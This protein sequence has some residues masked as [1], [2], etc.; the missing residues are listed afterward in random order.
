[1]PGNYKTWSI[2]GQLT[3]RKYTIG[4]Q[5]HVQSV[6]RSLDSHLASHTGDG[7]V[8]YT[9]QVE[10]A[11]STGQLHLQMELQFGEITRKRD[12]RAFC[13]I[14]GLAGAHVE[15]AKDPNAL[16]DY[17]RKEDSRVAGPWEGGVWSHRAGQ[18]RRTDMEAM[19][20]EIKAGTGTWEM[21]ERTPALGRYTRNIKDLRT[22]YAESLHANQE[23]DVVVT[24]IWGPS[25]SGKTHHVYSKHGKEHVFRVTPPNGNSDGVWF[26]G[27]D[28]RVHT[29]LLL[30]EFTGWIRYEAFKE[31]LDKWPCRLP[32]KGS[33]MWA[34]WDYVY[35]CSVRHP[36]MLY[37]NLTDRSELL[38]RIHTYI[39]YTTVYSHNGGPSIPTIMT[40]AQMLSPDD[41]DLVRSDAMI[42]QAMDMQPANYEASMCHICSYRISE[43][44]CHIDLTQGLSR[45][46]SINLCDA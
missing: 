34:A 26:D 40:A 25:G 38:R 20:E 30:D 8:H 44:M 21:V 7:L 17:C 1:M 16:R 22:A 24:Y 18:G 19:V 23:R 45:A 2:T 46:H 10:K 28:P 33:F 42:L 37:A 41:T 12:V 13:A 32:I 3:G 14:V 29:V 5:Q 11:P 31:Y 43:C 15:G 6:Q 39:N 27:Y 9:F 35:M 4:T 36:D